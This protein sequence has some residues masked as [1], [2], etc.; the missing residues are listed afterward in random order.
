[1][2]TAQSFHQ[3][4]IRLLLITFAGGC[5]ASHTRRRHWLTSGLS[6]GELRCAAA[7]RDALVIATGSRPAL[8]PL[9]P[10]SVDYQ[11]TLNLIAAAMGAG[12]SKVG[13][14]PRHQ[15]DSDTV[16]KLCCRQ[17]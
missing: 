16:P 5:L 4:G 12:I 14:K 1:M 3:I 7:R 6:R 9:G 2:R 8:D 10:Y 11:G 17:T 13:A 15:R